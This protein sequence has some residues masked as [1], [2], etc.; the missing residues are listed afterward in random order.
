MG[1]GLNVFTG[2]LKDTNKKSFPIMVYEFL[3]LWV[4]HKEVPVHYFS[5]FLYQ[6]GFS[7]YKD[8]IST[9]KYFK[10]ISS[11][12][13]QSPLFVSILNNKLLFAF[14][15]EKNKVPVPKMVGFNSGNMFYYG[16]NKSFLKSNNE[17]IAFY[18]TYFNKE[19]N[20]KKIFIKSIEAK[21]GTGIFMLKKDNYQAK[22]KSIGHLILSGSYIHQEGVVQ[23]TDIDK[24]YDKSINTLRFDVVVDKFQKTHLLG[25]VMRFGSGGNIIDNRSKGGFFVSMDKERGQLLQSGYRQMGYGGAKLFAHPDTDFVFDGYNIPFYSE[26]KQLAL[27]MSLLIPNK[28]V[29]WD[30]AIT[31][32]GPV[33][34]EGNHD[35]NITMSEVAY[36]G[37]LKHPVVKELLHSL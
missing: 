36:D 26:A 18:T 8:F 16:G 20:T 11:E 14:F 12:K 4:I 1:K 30:I 31:P 9:Q 21:G 22:I 33:I 5:R 10:L 29:G 13:I 7:N 2:I 6:K 23:N 32:S 27:N 35:S 15:C 19:T 37:Y 34:I 24:I 17:L 25:V 28:L 3:N